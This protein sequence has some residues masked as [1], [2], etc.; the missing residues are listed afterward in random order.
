M[1]ASEILLK[2]EGES[3]MLVLKA[4]TY[5]HVGLGLFC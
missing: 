1:A 3:T 5:W 4:L 2:T